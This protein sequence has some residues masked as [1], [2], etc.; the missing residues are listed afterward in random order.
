MQYYTVV[1]VANVLNMGMF[2][3]TLQQLSITSQLIK[4]DNLQYNTLD[5]W[6]A[7]TNDPL[8]KQLMF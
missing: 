1:D 6:V 4:S 7:G 3:E 5:R 2:V 8:T